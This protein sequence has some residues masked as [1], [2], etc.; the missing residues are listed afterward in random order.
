MT[1]TWA[2]DGTRRAQLAQR[3][4]ITPIVGSS[5]HKRLKTAHLVSTP[6]NRGRFRRKG[7]GDELHHINDWQRRKIIHQAL[8]ASSRQL[9]DF[10]A[11]RR[12]SSLVCRR[13]QP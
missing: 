13:S 3:A 12:A 6:A 10:A 2:I 9:C 11:I 7:G 5:P 4:Q 1:N 8:R